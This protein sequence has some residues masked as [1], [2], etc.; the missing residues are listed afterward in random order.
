MLTAASARERHL[1]ATPERLKRR[2]WGRFKTLCDHIEIDSE[3]ERRFATGLDDSTNVK[4]F[5]KLP[6]WFTVDTPI[7][8]YNQTANRLRGFGAGL[9]RPR[10]KGIE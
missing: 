1:W 3:V 7:G 10:D 6:A 4:F 2:D 8:P 5:M 9:P